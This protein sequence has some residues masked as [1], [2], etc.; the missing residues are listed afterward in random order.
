MKSSVFIGDIFEF[1]VP[2][3]FETFIKKVVVPCSPRLSFITGVT[4]LLGLQVYKKSCEAR[5]R[6][7]ELQDADTK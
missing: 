1:G 4:L 5:G 2:D 7:R 3:F 6:S